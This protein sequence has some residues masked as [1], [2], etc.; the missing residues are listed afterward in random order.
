MAN[1]F[2]LD[3]KGIRALARTP[4]MHAFMGATAQI[5]ADAAAG[6]PPRRTGRYDAE[7]EGKAMGFAS[8][9]SRVYARDF[10]SHWIEY[11]AGPSPVRGGRP[12]RAR[13]PLRN[14]V[15][16]TGLRYRSATGR[17]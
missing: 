16:I 10:K 17:D 7:I 9:K 5:V 1:R 3:R 14:A 13:H 6:L 11:G 8:A 2:S 12:F 4:E 15:L